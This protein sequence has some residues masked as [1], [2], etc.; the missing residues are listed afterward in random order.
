MS[1]WNDLVHPTQGDRETE[2][3]NRALDA[4]E[5]YDRVRDHFL[6]PKPA[7]PKA[8]LNHCQSHVEREPDYDSLLYTHTQRS[9]TRIKLTRSQ[10]THDID[11]WVEE[12]THGGDSG[13]AKNS[14]SL[15]RDPSSYRDM[16]RGKGGFYPFAPGGLDVLEN[17]LLEGTQDIAELVLEARDETSLQ[18]LRDYRVD[19]CQKQAPWEQT[20]I[21]M[22]DLMSFE[23]IDETA[24]DGTFDGTEGTPDVSTDGLPKVD[25]TIADEVDA[26][27]PDTNELHIAKAI[28]PSTKLTQSK[29]REWAHVIPHSLP[30]PD[31][32]QKV[33]TMAHQFPFELDTFQKHAVYHLERGD[34]VFVAAHTSAGK[35]VVAEYAI[36]LAEKH[37]TK[38]IYTSPIKALSNQKFRD[39]KHTFG[40]DV[41]IL[42]GD[43]Q[44]RPE[45][46]CLIMTTEILRSMLYRGADLIRDVEFVIFDE[47]HYVNDLERGVVWEEVIIMLPAHV[48][49]ILL[50]AT[51]P[52][53]K[54]FADWVG[55]TKRKDIFVISTT[56]RPVPLEHYL[57]AKKDLYKIVDADR[58]FLSAGWKNANDAMTKSDKELKGAA[59]GRG[60]GRG[61]RGVPQRGRGGSAPRSF[62]AMQSTDRNLYIH[63]VGFLNKRQLLPVVVFTFSK[64]KCEEYA[65]ALSNIDLS[66]SVEKSEVHV[67]RIR[68]LLARGI[69]VHH[70]GLLPII[71]E[72]VEIMFSRGLVKILFA[73]ETFAMGVNMPAR[74]VVFSSLRKHDGRSFRD[75]LPGEYTQMSGRAGRRGLD[76]TGVVI[77][78]CGGDEPPDMT[79]LNRMILGQPTKLESQF[80]LTYNMILNLLRVEALK[81]EEMIKRSFSENVNQKMLPDQKRLFDESEKSLKGLQKLDCTICQADIEAFYDMSYNVLELNRRMMDKI[82]SSP[83]GNKGL[84]TGRVVIVNNMVL[85]NTLAV[86]L[87][88]VA[89]HDKK[90]SVLAIVDRAKPVNA[91]TEIAEIAPM[92]VNHLKVI[93]S[94]RADLESI[95]ID[96]LDIMS[97]TKFSIKVDLDAVES[98]H[99]K[100][101]LQRIMSELQALS[102]EMKTNGITE[103][104]WSKLRELEFQESA[105]EKYRLL[106]RLM[107]F[108]CNQCPDL[109]EHYAVVHTQKVLQHRLDDLKHTISDQ[110]LELLPDYEQR[111]EVLKLMNFIDE[112]GTVQLKGRVACEINSADELLLTELILNNTLADFEPAEIVALLSCF[113]FQEKNASE[114]NLTPKLEKGKEIILENATHIADIQRACGLPLSKEDY[115]FGFKFGLVEVVYEW[116]RG[117]PFKQITDLTDVLEGSIVRTIVRLD[118]TCREVKGTARMIGDTSLYKKME[119]AELM[120]KRDIVFAASLYF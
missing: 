111:V 1:L 23:E 88:P 67:L 84:T 85:R 93:D 11:G 108:Q 79:T 47:V 60:T 74:S 3:T 21:S 65:S 87:R 28:T 32:H 86:V 91:H 78:A 71:K 76:P 107:T 38:A 33:P 44:I 26:L 77:I 4:S 68:D 7:F 112:N 5:S 13:T 97:V 53:T 103:Y 59:Q 40:D 89:G 30:F 45:A 113:I 119:E 95:S 25:P 35:T 16:V 20:F 56:Q 83:V 9:K 105:K 50:S 22:K 80:R 43:V 109:D 101:E 29:A 42:T 98:D 94:S 63:L 116:A 118:D 48:T 64:K 52:N 46:S 8:W 17:N 37:M 36:A 15:D 51:I 92:P 115:V 54:E 106:S 117:M 57:Y 10:L 58:N 69:G 39:F 90:F 120:I 104:D 34:S 41:G 24:T 81:V 100:S 99:S 72:M 114:P 82:V 55:R 110:N 2:V 6:M 31:F 70:G 102:I 62:S 61:Q 12:T 75:L 27:L 19:L 73:T 96:A 14:T 18:H 49:L 66:S